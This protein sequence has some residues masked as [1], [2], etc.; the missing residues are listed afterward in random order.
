MSSDILVDIDTGRLLSGAWLTPHLYFWLCSIWSMGYKSRIH[1]LEP[2]LLPISLQVVQVT[3]L[4]SRVDHG[5]LSI[6]NWLALYQVFSPM[7]ITEFSFEQIL[8]LKS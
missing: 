3:K 6:D 2:A 5:Y 4:P 8:I 7:M 1:T